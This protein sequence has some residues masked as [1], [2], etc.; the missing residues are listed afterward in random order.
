VADELAP[1]PLK[2]Q[3]VDLIAALWR[4]VRDFDALLVEVNPLVL[5][6]RGPIALDAKIVLDGYAA[7]RHVKGMF[8]WPALPIDPDD[9][10]GVDYVKLDGRVGVVG[11]GAGLSW[12]I[13]D[14]LAARKVGCSYI[15]DFTR[16]AV[17]AWDDLFQGSLSPPLV[18]VIADGL[19]R[20]RSQTAAIL[21]NLMS[22][23]TP[24]DGL[25]RHALAAL[26]QTSPLA[27]VVHVGG[28]A[29]QA[30][31]G[32]LRSSGQAH[33]GEIEA[34]IDLVCDLALA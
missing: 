8:A 22:G 23:G 29:E 28:N 33:A 13:A 12:Y 6:E 21:V 24:V 16:A 20:R 17:G 30:A 32:L 1:P 26:A 4:C 5:T 18:Q 19:T 2:S 34:A 10:A 27:A 9:Q 31:L 14:R 11:L 3:I 25:T 7:G 15:Y